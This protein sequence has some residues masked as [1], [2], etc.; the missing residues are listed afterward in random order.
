MHWRYIGDVG[1]ASATSAWRRPGSASSRMGDAARPAT[2]TPSIGGLEAG[3]LFA[4]GVFRRR[5]EV[6]DAD[7]PN[8]P[9]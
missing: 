3:R 5:A 2:P 1:A 8:A 6:G 4:G 7:A 9:C